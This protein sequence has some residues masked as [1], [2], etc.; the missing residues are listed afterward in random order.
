MTNSSSSNATTKQKKELPSPKALLKTAGNNSKE[1]IRSAAERLFAAKGFRNTTLQ[2]IAKASGANSALVAYYFGSKNGLLHSVIDEK[3]EALGEKSLKSLVQTKQDPTIED[4]RLFLRAMFANLRAD[5]IFHRIAQRVLV[6]GEEMRAEM[7][8]RLWQ[9][10]FDLTGE[11][12]TRIHKGKLTPHE[13]EVRCNIMCGILHGYAQLQ[14]FL[15]PTLKSTEPNQKV[16]DDY[17]SYFLDTL[18]DTICSAN[19]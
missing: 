2:D 9:P 3:L 11:L 15:F 19:S 16:L 1:A 5:Q 7:V 6:E 18:L 4:I 12:I 8:K 14:S 13:I 10:L 17:E